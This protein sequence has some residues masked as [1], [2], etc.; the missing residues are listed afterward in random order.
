MRVPASSPSHR[1]EVMPDVQ[2]RTGIEPVAR[3]L[4]GAAGSSEA[5]V[6]VLAACGFEERRCPDTPRPL[7]VTSST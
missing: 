5:T 3:S 4:T 7:I 1:R 2:Y 6:R